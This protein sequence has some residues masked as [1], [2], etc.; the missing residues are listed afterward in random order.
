[1]KRNLK[2]GLTLI[3][4]GSLLSIMGY[5]MLRNFES[6]EEEIER[7]KPLETL[8]EHGFLLALN[9]CGGVFIFGGIA[10]ILV[11]VLGIDIESN[12]R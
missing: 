8:T 12:E 9:F 3:V 2:V 6:R 7:V 4:I 5:T 1:M 10:V 11:K